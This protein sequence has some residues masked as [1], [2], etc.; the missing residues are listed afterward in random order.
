LLTETAS[1]TTQLKRFEILAWE[2]SLRPEPL[3][4]HFPFRHCVCS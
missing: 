1:Q 2:L 4:L 3:K